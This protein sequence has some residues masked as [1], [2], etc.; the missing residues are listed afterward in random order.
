MERTSQQGAREGDGRR[1]LVDL[2]AALLLAQAAATSVERLMAARRDNL[3]FDDAY[4][5]L[6]YAHNIRHGLG[7]AW[8]LD[9]A[10]TYGP[11]SLLWSFCVLLLSYLPTDPWTQL[12]L[13]SWMCSL[14]AVMAMAWA[15][16]A[17]ARSEW[18]RRP[19]PTLALIAAPLFA[20][21]L[22]QG[23][24][25]NGMETMLATALCAVF[26]GLCLLWR[27]GRVAPA[28][29]G[30]AGVLLFLAR[31]E[32]GLVTVLVP[33]LV[34]WIPAISSGDAMGSGQ[35]RRSLRGLLE[36]YG[37]FCAGVLIELALCR[38]YF[39][40]PVPLSVHMKGGAAY[41]GYGDVWYPSLMLIA[42]LSALQLFVAALVLL[43]R[44][45]DLRLVLCG[46]IPAALVFAYLGTVTQIMGFD[47]R[48][49]VPYAPL[50]VVPAV[51][52]LDGWL[53][54]PQPWNEAWPGHALRNRGAVTA[55]LLILFFLF[56]SQAVQRGFRLLEH[57]H[58][59]EYDP[60]QLSVA[61]TTPLPSYDWQPMMRAVTDDLIAP[62]PRGTTVASSEV[63]YLGER[64]SGINIIDLAGLNDNDIALHGF[65]MN[66]LLERKPDLIW[67][68]NTSYTYQ[69]G[70]MFSDP[71]F[72]AQ[73]DVY[74][75]AG[76]FG[77]AIRK[78]S[79]YCGAIERQF[80]IFWARVY[81][82]YDPA[83]YLVRSVSWSG[84]P[85][86][87]RNR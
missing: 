47:S 65:G 19:L 79:P 9:G 24:Q 85:H 77:I 37:V 28:V 7:F 81:P 3:S 8:N 38:L 39:G 58:H 25:F 59:L 20:S 51:L 60:A 5:F 33:A 78:D 27:A 64:A 21:R 26:F 18:L 71:A 46:V 57:G 72:L 11:T 29:V 56:H 23:D 22:F 43:T 6:R 12:L 87:V 42:F 86:S 36:L 75:D 16:R 49:Y 76:N 53:A 67:M 84:V 30:G 14:A 10:H 2:G 45:R 70:V 82:R 32:S 54:F 63:G 74:A 66:R 80:R 48:Y 83:A 41:R 44:R 68:P 34:G 40:T 61:A 4:M 13:G 52:V 1:R 15:V 69:R 17:N 62:L 31:P 35:T 55:V 50:L 73:Y